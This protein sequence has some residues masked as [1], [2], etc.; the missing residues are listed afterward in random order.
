MHRS[1][2][3]LRGSPTG[4]LSGGPAAYGSGSYGTEAAS[5]RVATGERVEA[6][7][8]GCA[9]SGRDVSARAA[10]L[11]VGTYHVDALS[12]VDAT[13]DPSTMR[14][15]TFRAHRRCFDAYAPACSRPARRW[16]F[17]LQVLGTRRP[18]QP[19]HEQRQ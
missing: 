15:P 17:L 12:F 18:P 8:D 10:Y 3:P 16:R 19:H 6:I 11:R 9:A 4:V 7:A 1:A 2:E 14:A 13:R 5:T